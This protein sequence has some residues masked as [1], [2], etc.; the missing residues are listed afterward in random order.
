MEAML[1]VE[2]ADGNG[3]GLGASQRSI[4]ACVEQL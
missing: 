2:A 1:V 3:G 4:L